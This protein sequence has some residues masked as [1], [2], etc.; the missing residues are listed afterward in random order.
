MPT[1][2][3]TTTAILTKS[4]IARVNAPVPY[5]SSA[6]KLDAKGK[7]LTVAD[8]S[9]GLSLS[10][11]M[12]ITGDV[13]V[14]FNIRYLADQAKMTPEFKVCIA[15]SNDPAL[16]YGADPDALYVLMPMRVD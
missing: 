14:G 3:A 2:T 7:C 10:V 8:R 16:I 9:E 12:Q 5:M 1:V 13:T 6:A 4:M 11:P 15:S